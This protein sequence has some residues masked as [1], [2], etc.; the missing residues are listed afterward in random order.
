MNN[1]KVRVRPKGTF[2][3]LELNKVLKQKP[4]KEIAADKIRILVPGSKKRDEIIP[5]QSGMQILKNGISLFS[6]LSSG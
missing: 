6:T 2:V 5:I 1:E 4:D 3:I